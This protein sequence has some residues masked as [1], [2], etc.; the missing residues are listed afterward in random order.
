MPVTLSDHELS[1]LAVSS[2]RYALGRK[3][4]VVGDVVR[5]VQRAAPDLA[6]AARTA[7]AR[8]VR[9]ALAEGR[10]GGWIDVEAWRS[11]LPHLDSIPAR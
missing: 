4:Y 10:A 6:P 8:D 3:T 2:V 1:T 5:F 11:L 9:D 7:I